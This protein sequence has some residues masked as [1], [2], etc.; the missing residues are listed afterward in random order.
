MEKENKTLSGGAESEECT[1]KK[2]NITI[3]KTD[4][5]VL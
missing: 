3:P 2:E 4:F 5:V 1:M